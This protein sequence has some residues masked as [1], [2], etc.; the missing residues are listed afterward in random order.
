MLLHVA[1]TSGKM[2]PERTCGCRLPSNLP[3]SFGKHF[4]AHLAE[5]VQY[6]NIID[7]KKVTLIDAAASFLGF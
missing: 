6:I 4:E 7:I 1:S 5:A 2:H 3:D